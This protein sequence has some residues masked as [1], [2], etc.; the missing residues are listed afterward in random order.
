MQL[1]FKFRSTAPYTGHNSGTEGIICNSI[2]TLQAEIEVLKYRHFSINCITFQWQ[3]WWVALVVMIFQHRSLDFY[4]NVVR[5][6][7][8]TVGDFPS[9]PFPC[10]FSFLFRQGYITPSYIFIKSLCLVVDLKLEDI[11]FLSTN[12][13]CVLAPSGIWMLCSILCYSYTVI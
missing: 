6:W 4:S 7:E 12:P 11:R 9:F 5:F 3:I 8:D 10:S 13:F 1:L 2:I